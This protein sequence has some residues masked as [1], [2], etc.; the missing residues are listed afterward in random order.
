MALPSEAADSGEPGLR[1]M[2]RHAVVAPRHPPAALDAPDRLFR[3]ASKGRAATLENASG[4]FRI[5]LQCSLFV[6]LG[7]RANDSPGWQK[8]VRAFF[9]PIG[10]AGGCGGLLVAIFLPGGRKRG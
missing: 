9:V 7:K 3:M 10:F 4:G 1:G 2:A 5:Q 6:P 8:L